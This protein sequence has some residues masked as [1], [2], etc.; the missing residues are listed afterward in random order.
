M[1]DLV[2][3]I[4]PP[5]H[6]DPSWEATSLCLDSA[7]MFGRRYLVPESY[8]RPIRAV[9]WERANGDIAMVV[10]EYDNGR[11]AEVC[12]SGRDFNTTLKFWG[13]ALSMDEVLEA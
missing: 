12:L 10:A 9:L 2:Y 4:V 1:S 5:K 8:G 6:T 7:E 11:R 13:G 3:G